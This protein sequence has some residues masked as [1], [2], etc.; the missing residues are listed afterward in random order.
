MDEFIARL[1]IEHYRKELATERDAERRRSI[2]RLLAE[3]Q[4]KLTAMGRPLP[5]DT[6]ADENVSHLNLKYYRKR[7]ETETDLVIRQI[8]LRLIIEEEAK[9]VPPEIRKV[10]GGD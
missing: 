5:L 1:N 8:L 3:E 6:D 10:C 2:S 9:L 4:S 7:L